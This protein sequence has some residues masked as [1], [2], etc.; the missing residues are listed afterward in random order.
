MAPAWVDLCVFGGCNA[1]HRSL[2]GHLVCSW[3]TPTH[4]VGRMQ[5]CRMSGGLMCSARCLQRVAMGLRV[6]KHQSLRLNL[7]RTLL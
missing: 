5:A 1:A 6:T 2:G 7:S 4:C 3:A